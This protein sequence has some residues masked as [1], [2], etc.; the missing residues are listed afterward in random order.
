MYLQIKCIEK[1]EKTTYE[2]ALRIRTVVLDYVRKRKSGERK[3]KIA[4]EADILSLFLQNPEIFDEELIVDEIL[5]FF[6]AGT[7]TTTFVT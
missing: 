6:A 3:S 2:N 1:Y 4:G 7:I 5:D